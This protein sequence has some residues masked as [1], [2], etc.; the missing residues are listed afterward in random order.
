MQLAPRRLI[1]IHANLQQVAA[2]DL[3]NRELRS[4]GSDDTLAKLAMDLREEGKLSQIHED[5]QSRSDARIICSL[6]LMGDSSNA[7]N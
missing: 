4:N 1:V 7:G 6:G 2:T 5:E 3:L